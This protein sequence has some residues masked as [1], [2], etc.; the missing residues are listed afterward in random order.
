MDYLC[1]TQAKPSY[2]YCQLNSVKKTPGTGKTHIR[3]KSAYN[4]FGSPARRARIFAQHPAL[5]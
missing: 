1:T 3:K 4:S 5:S 2:L